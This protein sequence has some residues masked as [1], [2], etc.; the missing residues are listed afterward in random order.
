MRHCIAGYMRDV[1]RGN[2]YAYHVNHATPATI[3]VYVQNGVIVRVDQIQGVRNSEPDK[4]VLEIV[5]DWFQG[6][7]HSRLHA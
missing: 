6:L 2:Y 4:K 1:F 7:V 3:G 5:N